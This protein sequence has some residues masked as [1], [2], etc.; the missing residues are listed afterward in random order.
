MLIN[1]LSALVISLLLSTVT[2]GQNFIGILS[3]VNDEATPI[4]GKMTSVKFIKNG[5]YNYYLGKIHQKNVVVLAGGVGFVNTAIA[6]AE[7]IHHYHPDTLFFIGTAGGTSEKQHIGDIYLINQATFL[8]TGNPEKL[9]PAW[10]SFPPNPVTGQVDRVT[11][12]AHQP[13]LTKAL[14]LS[15]KFAINAINDKGQEVPAKIHQGQTGSTEHFPNNR[16]D[17]NK[18]KAIKHELTDMETASFYK[19]CLLYSKKCLAIRAIADLIPPLTQ[20]KYTSWNK[21]NAL[22]ASQNSAELAFK[23]ISETSLHKDNNP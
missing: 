19:T 10:P 13:L 20:N 6:T 16:H 9:K 3:A 2:Y 5:L 15:N 18:L 14:L 8:D 12:K 21:T 17:F 23:I 7:M 22:I 1:R 11:Y 4:L